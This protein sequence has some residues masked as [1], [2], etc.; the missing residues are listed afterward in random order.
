MSTNS[1]DNARLS[2]LDAESVRGPFP[3]CK[4]VS[5]WNE[6]DGNLGQLDGIVVDAEARQVQYLVVAAGGTFSRRRRYLLPFSAARVDASRR[7]LCVDA[8]K[9]DLA[10]CERF[11]S[12]AFHR[13]S[14]DD[15]L[16]A[17]F[18]AVQ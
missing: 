5:V 1:N 7:A 11:D 8:N 3:T 12:R 2:Y 14:D 6:D 18:A 17:L 9:T 4:N 16:S 15:L 13:F 10:L